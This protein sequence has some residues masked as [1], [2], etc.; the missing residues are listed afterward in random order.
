MRAGNRLLPAVRSGFRLKDEQP[1]SAWLKV[2]TSAAASLPP[3]LSKQRSHILGN[4]TPSTIP[5]FW[6]TPTPGFGGGA[7]CFEFLSHAFG[8]KRH[9]SAPNGTGFSIFGSYTSQF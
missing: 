6:I 5:R 8:T 3:P 4:T 1:L 2:K 7:G 9:F